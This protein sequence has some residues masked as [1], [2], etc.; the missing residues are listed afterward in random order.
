L[1]RGRA[2]IQEAGISVVAPTTPLEEEDM[3]V[4]DRSL[5]PNTLSKLWSEAKDH[6]ED[7]I[8]AGARAR[9]KQL[10]EKGVRDEFEDLIRCKPHERST[11][12]QDYR[13]GVHARGLLTVLGQVPE[14]RIPRA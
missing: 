2:L 8:S 14:L 4:R 12:R 10:I 1:G 13:N 7:E 11:E 3:P 9:V 5:S 6:A